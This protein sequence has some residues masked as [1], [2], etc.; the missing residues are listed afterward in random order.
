MAGTASACYI[1][2]ALNSDTGSAAPLYFTDMNNAHQWMCIGSTGNIGMGVNSPGTKL[3]VV[4]SVRWA[5][6]TGDTYQIFSTSNGNYNFGAQNSYDPVAY[7]IIQVNHTLAN[8]GGNGASNGQWAYTLVQAGTRV[9]G[10]GM[11]PNYGKIV[12]GSGGSVTEGSSNGITV[13]VQNK[14][15]GI[16]CNAPAYSLDVSGSVRGDNFITVQS[17][18]VNVTGGTRYPA[19]PLTVLSAMY[20]YYI[21]GTCNSSAGFIRVYRQNTTS[22]YTFEN[23]QPFGGGTTLELGTNDATTGYTINVYANLTQINLQWSLTRLSY[24]SVF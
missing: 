4:G 2:A 15:L 13:D 7:G 17:N 12:I 23:N 11:M 1:E 3:D 6:G 20:A 18:I 21:S 9:N 5:Q 14:R 22:T 19:L 8:N 24:T 10:I 16:A